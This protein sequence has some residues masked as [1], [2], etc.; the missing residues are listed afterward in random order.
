VN[1]LGRATGPP[2]WAKYSPLQARQKQSDARIS[3]NM[4]LRNKF[5]KIAQN[6]KIMSVCFLN[7]IP[8]SHICRDM[9]VAVFLPGLHGWMFGSLG[10]SSGPSKLVHWPLQLKT[11]TAA[12]FICQVCLKNKSQRQ[13]HIKLG[14][15]MVHYH[16]ALHPPFKISVWFLQLKI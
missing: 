6:W 1:Q 5:H 15:L 16:F 12:N 4:A 10:W 11:G 2:Q 7:Y 13:S 3:V 8:M 14:Y 9:A